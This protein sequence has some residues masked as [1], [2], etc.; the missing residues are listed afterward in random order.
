MHEPPTFT[1]LYKYGL[2]L[3]KEAVKFWVWSYSEWL[4]GSCFILLL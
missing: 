4:T 2:R 3:W 1:F